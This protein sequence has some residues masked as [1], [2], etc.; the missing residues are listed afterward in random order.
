MLRSVIVRVAGCPRLCSSLPSWTDDLQH[1]LS[2]PIASA[3][4]LTIH[5][6]SRVSASLQSA[7]QSARPN[8]SRILIPRLASSTSCNLR[9]SETKLWWRSVATSFRVARRSPK[10]S[11]LPAQSSVVEA[12]RVVVGQ[13]ASHPAASSPHS[14]TESHGVGIGETR[15]LQHSARAYHALRPHCT[16]LHPRM[17]SLQAKGGEAQ[18]RPL[19]QGRILYTMMMSA[20]V[21]ARGLIGTC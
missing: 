4:A 11:L 15:H 18:C 5:C 1:C 20:A 6:S 14:V 9:R 16:Q 21:L 19:T 10:S 8:V 13:W 7:Q 17:C 2:A 3:T 12:C